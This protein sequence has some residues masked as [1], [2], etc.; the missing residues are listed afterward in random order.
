MKKI[1]LDFLTVALI[2]AVLFT[3]FI[4]YALDNA[5]R[6]IIY[7][8]NKYTES[9]GPFEIA[10]YEIREA[11]GISVPLRKTIPPGSPNIVDK[12]REKQ[13]P[14]P[15][16]MPPKLS[17]IQKSPRQAG[18]IHAWSSIDGKTIKA[19]FVS[20]NG[21]SLTI[22]KDGQ[23]FTIPFEKLS[24]ASIVLAKQLSQNAPMLTTEAPVRS[25]GNSNPATY[26]ENKSLKLRPGWD[27]ALQKGKV[28]T[29]EFRHVLSLAGCKA[30]VDLS[31]DDTVE[32]YRGI[33]YLDPASKVREYLEKELKAR[34][35]S[36][37]NQ[38]NAA[39]FPALSISSYDYSG[40]FEG[41]GHFILVVDASDQVVGVQLLQNA[42]KSLM[43]NAHSNQWSV[44]NFLQSRRKGT[45]TYAIDYEV[46]SHEKTFEVLSELIDSNRKSREWVKLIMPKKFANIAMH[47]IEKT[48]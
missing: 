28:S 24:S 10:I 11:L 7:Y 32:L 21:E 26:G 1:N 12:K 4:L 31:A 41:F 6:N 29:L 18:E 47:V 42:P 33:R 34:P 22:M 44:Y 17:P 46:N 25:V 36:S 2:A 9:S 16:P 38:I 15:T 23:S 30:E 27:T 3:F 48:D 8:R 5:S 14:L 13:E 40:D 35:M 39:G 37:R 45:K 19:A 20:Q 43:L